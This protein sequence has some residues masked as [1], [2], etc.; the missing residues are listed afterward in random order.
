MASY[1]I[2]L[3]K[4]NEMEISAAQRTT[5]RRGHE[6]GK[7]YEIGII[8]DQTVPSFVDKSKYVEE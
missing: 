1:K 4:R 2:G 6:F 3:K 5:F 7:I 8:P